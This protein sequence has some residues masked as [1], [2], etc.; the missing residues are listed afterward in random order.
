MVTAVSSPSITTA[1][2]KPSPPRC[3]HTEKNLP[4]LGWW[5]HFTDVPGYGIRQRGNEW[6]EASTT[7]LRRSDRQNLLVPVHVLK[8]KALNLTDAQCIDGKQE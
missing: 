6:A 8:T 3:V 5:A 4:I 2:T 1:R 7:L